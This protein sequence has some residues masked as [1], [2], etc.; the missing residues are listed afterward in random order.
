[1]A[2]DLKVQPKPKIFAETGSAF[3]ATDFSRIKD[4]PGGHSNVP[5]KPVEISAFSYSRK[6]SRP[7][8]TGFMKKHT[9]FGGTLVSRRVWDIRLSNYL[10]QQMRH[11]LIIFYIEIYRVVQR[12]HRNRHLP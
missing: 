12:D 3:D 6:T 9:G 10:R 11:Y 1:M 5:T 4:R 2:S 8:P 7:S